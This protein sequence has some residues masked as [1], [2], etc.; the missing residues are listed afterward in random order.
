MTATNHLNI[1]LQ[2]AIENYYF[3]FYE[4]L[5]VL[6]VCSPP[7]GEKCISIHWIGLICFPKLDVLVVKWI[8]GACFSGIC[9]VPDS[10]SLLSREACQKSVWYVSVF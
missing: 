7:D 2:C 9:V 1:F 4:K 3:T 10:S 5:P 8:I 6:G